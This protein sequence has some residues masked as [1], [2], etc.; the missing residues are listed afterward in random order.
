MIRFRKVVKNSIREKPDGMQDEEFIGLLED[1]FIQKRFEFRSNVSIYYAVAVTIFS[2]ILF[3][4]VFVW[5]SGSNFQTLFEKLSSQDFINREFATILSLSLS[6]GMIPPIIFAMA[7]LLKTKQR[8]AE[9][10]TINLHIHKYNHKILLKRQKE[11]SGVRIQQTPLMTTLKIHLR[12]SQDLL[13]R[14]SEDSQRSGPNKKISGKSLEY[15]KDQM[16]TLRD[17]LL[18]LDNDRSKYEEMLGRQNGQYV[19]TV[20]F[21]LITFLEKLEREDY[22][23]DE[24]RKL[25]E[26]IKSL[27]DSIIKEGY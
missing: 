24:I 12:N 11:M 27:I 25:R 22:S 17:F 16:P 26:N 18:K 20:F 19:Y 15:L 2:V 14:I 5:L 8:N 13:N 9:L 10:A 1:D 21:E 6:I 7:R 3:G 23:I 4:L